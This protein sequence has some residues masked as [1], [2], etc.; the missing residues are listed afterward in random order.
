MKLKYI[1]PFFLLSIFY[2]CE[3]TLPDAPNSEDI[4]AEPIDGLTGSQL[5]LHLRGD[6]EFAK[7]Y[8]VDEGL[9]PIF[10]NTGCERCHVGDGKGNP[11]NNVVRFGKW[12]NGQFDYMEAFGGPQLQNRSIDNYDPEMI[13]ESATS[14]SMRTPPVNVGLGFLQALH[15]STIINLAD[16]DDIDGD[17]IS[18]KINWVLPQPHFEAQDIHVSNGGM[19]IGRFGKKAK[20]IDLRSQIIFAFREDIGLSTDY[21]P[22]DISNP[23]VG[24]NISDAVADPEVSAATVDAITFYLR[25]LKAPTRRNENDPNVV[26]GSQIFENIGCAKCHIPTLTTAKSEVEALSEVEFHAYTD[27]LLHDMGD[28]SVYDDNYPEGSAEGS[29]WRTPPLWG[30]G[31]AQ[32]SQ[33]NATYFLHDGSASTL[34]EAIRA[35]AYGEAVNVVLEYNN[36]TETEKEQLMAFLNSL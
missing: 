29:E 28:N 13:P 36:L 27:L 3:K 5:A 9:G 20:E 12:E 33:G 2:A 17:G 14:I 6:E 25:T 24:Q 26:S 11:I 21:A 34:E 35:H 10:I 32:T 18:G 19:Y 4:L 15:D 16:P 31:L 22:Y 30:I 8:G 1:L 23:L 7:S